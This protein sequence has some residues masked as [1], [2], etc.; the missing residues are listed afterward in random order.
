MFSYFWTRTTGSLDDER[1]IGK[2]FS[3]SA[4][5][6]ERGAS[7]SEGAQ[8]RNFRSAGGRGGGRGGSRLRSH[9]L[10]GGRGGVP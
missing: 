4:S 7:D 3:P 1:G 10:P 2:S 8:R 9:V 5:R 6:S